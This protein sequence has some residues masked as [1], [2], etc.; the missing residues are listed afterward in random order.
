MINELAICRF[1]AEENL[2]SRLA[3]K[4]TKKPAMPEKIQMKNPRNIVE[5]MGYWLNYEHL[6][7]RN[8]LFSE[9]NLNTPVGNFL[10]ARHGHLVKPEFPHPILT[11]VK[12]PGRNPSIDYVIVND[13]IKS[14]L[15]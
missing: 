7:K 1:F 5:C 10:I 12:S 9:G 13:K 2:P 14:N 3:I 15:L 11:P 4:S 8:S 6:C